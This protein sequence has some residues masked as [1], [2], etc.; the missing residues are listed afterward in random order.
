MVS[1]NILKLSLTDLI[2]V[3]PRVKINS[4]Y[5]SDMFLL[6]FDK[7]IA[8]SWWCTFSATQCIT[9]LNTALRRSYETFVTQALQ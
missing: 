8:I 9:G 6:G 3:D 7:V 1:I 5:Y 4:G 2:F